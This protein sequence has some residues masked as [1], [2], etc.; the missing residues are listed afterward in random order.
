MTYGRL[1]PYILAGS[2]FLA[3][4]CNA[5]IRSK[6]HNNEPSE[7]K[8]ETIND[9]SESGDAGD[10]SEEKTE[11]INPLPIDPTLIP[12][13]FTAPFTSNGSTY[14]LKNGNLVVTDQNYSKTV[15]NGGAIYIYEHLT[16]KL[17]SS[18]FGEQENDYLGNNASVYEL[19][20]GNFTIRNPVILR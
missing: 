3:C 16:G 4:G 8:S 18:I 5:K 20:N 9:G 12:I 7:T 10:D 1:A 6:R 11:V 15:P 13:K 2:F 17:L 14:V 19:S